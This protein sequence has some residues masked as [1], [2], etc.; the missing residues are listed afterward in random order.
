[1]RFEGMAIY[2][3]WS[4]MATRLRFLVATTPGRAIAALLAAVGVYLNVFGI[5]LQHWG[6]IYRIDLDVYRLGGQAYLA[7]G[8]IYGRLPDTL[9]GVNLPFTYPPIAAIIFAPL[10]AIPFWLANALVTLAT[11]VCLW[12]SLRLI[13]KSLIPLRGAELAW[14]AVY[15][16]AI[17]MWIEPVRQTLSFGQVN[18]L[19][20]TLVIVD[21][22]GGRGKRWQGLLIGVAIAIKLTPAVFLAYFLVRRDW[23]SLINGIGATIIASLVGFALAPTASVTYWTQA[24]LDPSRI[25]GLA[26]VSNQSFNGLLVRLGITH[27]G[28]LAWAGLCAVVGL[29]LLALMQ[30]LFKQGED[31]AALILMGFYALLASPVSWSHHWVWIAPALVLLVVWAA[32]YRSVGLWAMAVVGAIVYFGNV[33]WFAPRENDLELHWNLVQEIYGNAYV[34]W[35]LAFYVVVAVHSLRRP[36]VVPDPALTPTPAP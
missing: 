1:M 3:D 26:Y 35:G 6:N 11:V 17:F 20:M 9:V 25:G 36:V 7:G 27:G 13:L 24:L 32:R 5:T 21:V 8:D 18:V 10:G 16:A 12:V 23:R 28:G 29:L 22:I 31:T 33:I 30:R 19:L 15:A 4:A 2:S 14:L 34:W